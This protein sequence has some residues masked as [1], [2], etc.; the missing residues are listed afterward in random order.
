[1][2]VLSLLYQGRQAEFES[3]RKLASAGG[4]G[5]FGVVA[6]GVALD[7]LLPS[8]KELVELSRLHF[9]SAEKVCWARR[10][11]CCFCVGG[12]GADMIHRT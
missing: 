10:R 1:M 4:G 2:S 9:D 8:K 3:A 12:G 11:C 6:A 7:G 5:M